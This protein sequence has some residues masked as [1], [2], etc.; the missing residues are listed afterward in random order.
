MY[1]RVDNYDQFGAGGGGG[2]SI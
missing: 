1:G 2:G